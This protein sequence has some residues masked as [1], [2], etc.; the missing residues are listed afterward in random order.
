MKFL[1]EERSR[2]ISGKEIK[3]AADAV[4]SEL[5]RKRQEKGARELKGLKNVDVEE[6]NIRKAFCSVCP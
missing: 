1:Q 5:S 6:R 4:N 3:H 2:K